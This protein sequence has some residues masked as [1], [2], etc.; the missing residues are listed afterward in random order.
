MYERQDRNAS[1]SSI[2]VSL[3]HSPDENN[4]MNT[5]K[6]AGGDDEEE[7]EPK[8]TYDAE[9]EEYEDEDKRRKEEEDEEE[10]EEEEEDSAVGAVKKEK[11]PMEAGASNAEPGDNSRDEDYFEDPSTNQYDNTYYYYDE[12]E[13]G[14]RSRYEA[15]GKFRIDASNRRNDWVPRKLS[16]SHAIIRTRWGERRLSRRRIRRGRGL[17][18][19]GA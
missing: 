3:G 18:R 1:P 15:V 5:S 16:V 12:Y 10:E 4:V 19:L 9:A 2:D 8:L 17:E 11:S 6:G 7:E 14:N 13:N